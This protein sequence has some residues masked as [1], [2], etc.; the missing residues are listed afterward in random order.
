MPMIKKYQNKYEMKQIL[1]RMKLRIDMSS[2]SSEYD[3]KHKV[4]SDRLVGHNF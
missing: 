3:E 4:N 2:D 1:T